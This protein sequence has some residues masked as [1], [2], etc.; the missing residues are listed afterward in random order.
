L[1]DRYEVREL[2]DHGP[3]GSV[4]RAFDH[5]HNRDVALKIRPAGEDRDRLRDEARILL[6]LRPHPGMPVVREGFFHDNDYILVTDWVEGR[7]LAQ[8]LA[9]RG[10]PGLAPGVAI[11]YLG[12]LA[13]VLDHLHRQRPA[14]LHGDVKPNNAVLTSDGQV[15][16]VDVG[17]TRTQAPSG[18]SGYVAPEV[19]AGGAP[20]PAADIYGLAATAVA[21]LT[22]SAPFQ[23]QPSWEHLD[24][25]L[26][27]ALE[28]GI[29][30]GLVLNPARRPGSAGE[31]I[32][33]LQRALS[34]V[35]PTGV[36]TFCLTD[37]EGSTPLWDLHAPAMGEVAARTETII[38]EAVESVGGR[39]IKAR[40]EGDSTLS[41][42][43]R[44]TDAAVAA[45]GIQRTL[46][47]ESWPEGIE[48]R[49][50]VA[51]H[52]GE[53]ELREGDYY[54]PTLN[55][56]ARLRELARG[57]Q[58]LCS[59]AT[60]ELISDE[61]P[62]GVTLIEVGERRL[63]SLSRPE[64]VYALGHRE[65]PAVSVQTQAPTTPSSTD[66]ED[67][68]AAPAPGSL[69]VGRQREW[70]EI[71]KAL[72]RS[73]RGSGQLLLVSGEA[74]IGKSRLVSELADLATRASAKVLWGRCYEG[75]AL[76]AFWP[77]VEVMRA[78][79]EGS[80]GKTLR[81]ALGPS[82]AF[83]AQI[84]PEIKEIVP[85]P[86]PVL[87]VEAAR[88]HLYDAVTR[89]L[90]HLAEESPMVLILE[91][92][93]WA[94]AA[95]LQ[96]LTFLAP[97]LM[98]ASILLVGTYRPVE[99][100]PEHP[101]AIALGSLVRKTQV[102]RVEVGGL[103]AADVDSFIAGTTGSP[104]P[105]ALVRAVHKRTEGNPFFIIELLRLL[106][107]R[108][109]ALSPEGVWASEVPAA[110]QDVV[111]QRISRLPEE[112][113]Q[114]LTV[115]AVVGEEFSLEL[116]ADCLEL[117]VQRALALVEAAL[118]AG[119]VREMG[120]QP[121]WFCFSHALVRE[122]LYEALTALRCAYLHRR[123]GEVLERELDTAAEDM[124]LVEIAYHFYRAAS[125]G[126]R[127]R[128]FA[129]A[130]RAEEQA[131]QRFAYDQ[132][133]EQL[134]RALRLVETMPPG[135]QRYR[136][137]LAVQLRL[138]QPARGLAVVEFGKA[139][140]RAWELASDLGDAREIL[141]ALW[142]LATF[143]ILRADYE[144][145]QDLG[146]ELLRGAEEFEQ[147][148][149]W[150]GHL[151]LGIVMTYQGALP[152]ARDHLEQAIPLIDAQHDPF[153]VEDALH[154]VVN[155]RGHAALVLW[156][157][158]DQDGAARMTLDNL[159]LA[160]A[161]PLTSSLAYAQHW[162]AMIEYL[163]GDLEMARQ[164]SEAALSRGSD[165]GLTLLVA[166]SRV[167]R[168]WVMAELGEPDLGMREINEGL[169][170]Q[171]TLG[172]RVA[173]D[174]SLGLMAQV[175]CRAGHPEK[176]LEAVDEALMEEEALGA[177]LWKAE[178]LRLKGE[179]LWALSP[180][181][182]DEAASNVRLAIAAAADQQAESLRVR[183]EGTLR[184]LLAVGSGTAEPLGT[185]GRS[186]M[187]EDRETIRA[188]MGEKTDHQRGMRG[189]QVHCD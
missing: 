122:T 86:P 144:R 7:T 15:V 130:L 178:L 177:H 49:V 100:T 94:D 104:A 179:A 46:A 118:R 105:A 50:R 153:L 27:G 98:E 166:R 117:N 47:R 120:Q 8:I 115:A 5:Q 68:V 189:W 9:D 64:F 28:R 99:L 125:A 11:D 171:R 141:A 59:R 169:E 17:L 172:L 40:G 34:G 10:D 150:A 146:R 71:R 164:R 90:L 143:H 63:R 123:V 38:A 72:G 145:A 187:A 14:V 137:E 39:L 140:S 103:L 95:S 53:A 157:L 113:A 132:A 162:A 25:V 158:G 102:V 30:R 81:D 20:S 114:L 48:L 148:V 41:V 156:L 75:E 80:V 139:A 175:H 24:P 183:A 181:R 128:A 77:W 35:L 147:P 87:D 176:A 173:V 136:R 65:L 108:Q 37:I 43:R 36:I 91:D 85:E 131:M 19:A 18:T 44:A 60:A 174:F 84:V 70:E 45:V 62:E 69:F 51:I 4:A 61:L 159:A 180:E 168:G 89:L 1:R 82:A 101:L 116:V 188:Q 110:V 93:H 142:R 165:R 126:M 107:S 79:A 161:L 112:A 23:V 21:L 111:R 74:G 2:L 22:G 58:I 66:A 57:D 76:P 3:P 155:A 124:L 167:L 133:R 127:D 16:L 42:F 55:R 106:E 109:D 78:L 52:T 29:R 129:Y 149:A 67:R 56:A 121:G 152:T 12:Q 182:A 119:I 92:L 96:L 138:I 83:L 185:T 135:P 163:R 32:A 134:Q 88:F 6:S 31:L 186:P 151:V 184:R 54:G 154:P 97:R 13:Q 26:A 160:E 73:F 33:R 170:A